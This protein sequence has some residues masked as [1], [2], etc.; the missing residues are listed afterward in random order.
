MRLRLVL[1]AF[2][3]VCGLQV[4]ARWDLRAVSVASCFGVT[5]SLS[6][7]N[8]PGTACSYCICSYQQ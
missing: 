8:K 3:R 1:M 7:C 5:G 4:L 6:L 2:F